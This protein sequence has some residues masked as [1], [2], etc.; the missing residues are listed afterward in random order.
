MA[1]GKRKHA[2]DWPSHQDPKAP[3]LG[4]AFLAEAKKRLK[5]LG[6]DLCPRAKSQPRVCAALEGQW[7]RE[8][9][10]SRTADPFDI[11]LR[12]FAEQVAVAWLLS[13]VFVRILEDRGLLQQRRI[14]GP[15]A[16]DSL[17][18]FKQLFPYLNE[19]DYLLAVFRELSGFAATRELFDPAHNLVWKLAPSADAVRELLALFRE[20]NAEAPSFRFGQENLRLLGDLYQDLDEGVRARFALLQTPDFVEALILDETLEPAI[21]ELGLDKVSL[22]DPTCGSGHFL[23]GAYDR[24]YRY[25]LEREPGRNVREVAELALGQVYGVDINPYAVA[26]ARFRLTLSFLDKAGFTKLQG[27]PAVHTN[28]VVAD[29][30]LHR[31]A[32]AS[33]QQHLGDF[34]ASNLADWKGRPFALEDEAEARAILGRR[35]AAVVGNP[36]YITEKDSKK[37]ELYRG[38]YTSAAGKFA[39]AAP[40]VERFF[41]LAAPSGFVGLINANSFMKREFGKKLIEEFLP[42]IDL[43]QVVDTSGAYIPGH[44]T[45]TVLLFGRRRAPAK[46]A[47]VRAVM[48]KRGEPATPDDPSQGKVWVSIRD[49]L[50]EVGFENDF[51]SVGEVPRET[52]NKHPWSLGGGGA[53]ELKELVEERAEK[54][55]KDVVESIGVGGMSNADDVYISATNT[56]PRFGVPHDLVRPLVIG[57]ELRDWGHS[58]SL[59]VYFPYSEQLELTEPT[60]RTLE[61]LWPYRTVLWS[62]VVFGGGTYKTAGR[63]WWEWHQVTKDRYRTPLSIAFAFVATHNHFVL[64]RGGAVFSRSAPIIK[65]PEGA[66]EEEHLALLA[67]L[68]SSTACFWMKQVFSPKGMHNGSEAN[69]TPFLVRFEFDG[70]KLARLPLPPRWQELGPMLGRLGRRLSNLAEQRASITFDALLT[71]TETV[72]SIETKVAQAVAAREE[73]C[74][75]GVGVQEEIDWLAYEA[76]GFLPHS[77][78]ALSEPAPVTLGHRPFEIVLAQD[79][80]SS[81]TEGWF[82]WN[83]TVPAARVDLSLPPEQRKR[84]EKRVAQI[85]PTA[86]LRLLESPIAKRR[87]VQPSG[88]AAQELESDEKVLRDQAN[89]W[90][91]R[92]IEEG[93]GAIGLRAAAKRDVANR[94]KAD[95]T[96][97]AVAGWAYRSGD[98]LDV[99]DRFLGE[100]AI[101]YIA[102]HRYTDSGLTK[103]AVWQHTWELQ[104]REDAGEKVGPIPAPPKYDVKDFRDPNYFR[105]RGKLDV[106]KERFISYPGCE[107]DQDGQPV[108]GWAGWNHLQRA[109]A[110]AALYQDRKQNEGWGKEKLT[111]MLAGLLEILP[112]LKQWHNEPSAEFGD[113]RLG[114]YFADFVDGQ[115]R[116]LGLTHEDL[117]AWRPPARGAKKKAAAAKVAKEPMRPR[118]KKTP[119]DEE[120]APAELAEE[121]P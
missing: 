28:L 60:G 15:G 31:D 5:T 50:H 56:W 10:Q 85:R 49:H 53:A 76:F 114:D 45:P 69:A 41:D 30:L 121:S 91:R 78:A 88:K 24:L 8:R 108:Y 27:A 22:I 51:I 58:G 7:Q 40:F 47:T 87:W 84:Y 4:A 23:L 62:R 82:R 104:R 32:D 89:A 36:P 67:Y 25:R 29:S 54:R 35:Y 2:F 17:Q 92:C 48:G 44:G 73:L 117:K 55:L 65:L 71:G 113:I 57:E 98:V 11:W 13:I 19:R 63:S 102:A 118:K 83:E 16:H 9:A 43:E 81:I 75:V 99:V 79:D 107:S 105:L 26:I 109:Q 64:D 66:S 68:N 116:E 95:A 20:P 119:K 90:L 12:H 3:F 39:L 14:A 52:F 42:K 18:S 6:D 111:P 37:R 86:E 106:P 77:E 97:V 46:A 61:F 80:P 70:T 94:L 115:C 120:L 34:A 96:F 100:D 21:R 59:E 72:D 33:G 103:H 74:R 38:L 93:V 110:L 101:P 112:W 1:K